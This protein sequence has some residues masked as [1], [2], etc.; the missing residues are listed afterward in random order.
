MKR[1][2]V[3]V[4]VLFSVVLVIPTLM[5]A[6]ASGQGEGSGGVGLALNQ[7]AAGSEANSEVEEV[8]TEENDSYN[9]E[10]DMEIAVYRSKTETIEEVP[11]EKY[12]MGVV[13]SEMSPEFEVEAL[14]AQALAARTY[15]VTHMAHSGD[16]DIQVP[17]GAM[18]TDTEMHQVYQNDEELKES[19]GEEYEEKKARVSEA[20]LATQG[21]VL[22]YDGKP[23]TASFFS[24]SNGHTE[25]SEDY[26]ADDI[27][28]LRSVESPW[29]EVSPRFANEVRMSVSEFQANLGIK[30]PEDGSVGTIVSR[31]DGGRVETVQIAD[32]EFTGREVR[33]ALELD[34]SDF[35][36]H[37][38]GEEVVIQTK[39]W[40]H[41]VGMS[42]Y[43]ADGMAKEGKS[44][45][46]IVA[47][48]YNDVVISEAEP[49]L[50][51]VAKSE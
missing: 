16:G 24:T 6:F 37:K 4:A 31:T 42:Q 47:H 17:D 11:L 12:I 18:V 48:Y 29:D 1:I 44:Y 14:K 21:E 10:D 22:T 15:I 28:Y 51:Q 26:W 40:G 49:I 39:G 34:S 9:E 33:D 50:A 2:F 43:G 19:W 35:Q 23:I 36:W 32:K 13:A 45:E 20:V 30:M 46:E 41:G 27:P 25:N 7:H 3:S 5:V 38:S 8:G